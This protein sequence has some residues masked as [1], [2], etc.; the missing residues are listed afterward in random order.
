M[1]ESIA[2]FKTVFMPKW[3]S[4]TDQAVPDSW[5]FRSS[6]SSTILMKIPALAEL[7]ALQTAIRTD[8]SIPPPMLGDV[9]NEED[10][11]NLT[12]AALRVLLFD[13]FVELWGAHRW[14]Q[15]GVNALTALFSLRARRLQQDSSLG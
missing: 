2:D 4:Y 6:P 14:L 15:V 1:L 13:H 8:D 12:P 11:D 10:E 7:Y 5:Y 3:D 9:S